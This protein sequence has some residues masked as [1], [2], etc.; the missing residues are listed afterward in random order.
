MDIIRWE[1][2]SKG[3]FKSAGFG[4]E[5]RAGSS[6]ACILQ[7]EALAEGVQGTE[8]ARKEGVSGP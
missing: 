8:S 2:L 7:R 6:V 5:K 4:A 3:L 1:G